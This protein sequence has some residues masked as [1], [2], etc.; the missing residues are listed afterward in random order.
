MC[1]LRYGIRLK[2]QMSHPY[3]GRRLKV[4]G[5][6]DSM[7][8]RYSSLSSPF[9]PFSPQIWTTHGP[10][11]LPLPQQPHRSH[12]PI[13]MN[14]PSPNN[15]VA[16]TSASTPRSIGAVPTIPTY[17]SAPEDARKQIWGMKAG[18]MGVPLWIIRVGM[19]RIFVLLP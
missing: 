15:P 16:I 14:V 5:G 17:A 12:P 19:I 13:N 10:L 7:C 6:R 9:N 11:Q 18:Y 1:R 3:F 2:T 4:M 8:Q